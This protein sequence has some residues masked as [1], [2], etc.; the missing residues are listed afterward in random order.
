MTVLVALNSALHSQT[1]AKHDVN[2]GGIE[3][4]IKKGRELT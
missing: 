4:D 1:T 2:E 3:Q